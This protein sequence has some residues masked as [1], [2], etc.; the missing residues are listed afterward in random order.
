MVRVVVTGVGGLVK[1]EML[2]VHELYCW[3]LYIIL[4]SGVMVL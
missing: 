4:M 1:G 3:E 2:L